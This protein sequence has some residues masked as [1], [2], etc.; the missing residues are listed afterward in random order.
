MRGALIGEAR[1]GRSGARRAGPEGAEP[2]W[3]W[4]RRRRA[5]LPALWAGGA[6]AL[7]AAGAGPAAA[8]GYTITDLGTMGGGSVSANAINN[9]GQV[10][11][12]VALTADGAATRAFLWEKGTMTDLG[13]LGGAQ[14]SASALND[15][16]QI[17]GSSTLA[18]NTTRH[19]FLWQ[20]GGMRDL[21]TLGG[22]SSY[23][24]GINA[25]GQVTGTSQIAGDGAKHAFLWQNGVMI[26][27][28][29]P[30]DNSQACGINA[31][32]HV[33][34]EVP[35]NQAFLWQVD[36]VRDLGS[37]GNPLCLPTA[38]NDRGQVV[39]ISVLGGMD[40]PPLHAFMADSDGMHDLG[41]LGG[42]WSYAFALNN[43]GDVVGYSNGPGFDDYHAFLFSGGVMQDLNALIP[44]DSGWVLTGAY[45]INDYGQI[46][47]AGSQGGEIHAFLLN[48][49]APA[50][51]DGLTASALSAS[52][53]ALS[54][55][56]NSSDETAFALWRQTD[57]GDFARIALVVPNTTGYTDSDLTP[58]TTYTY[59]VRAIGR[60]GASA[61][62]N[63]ATAITTPPSL[64]PPAFLS[65]RV[66]A[67]GGGGIEGI[68]QLAWSDNSDNET[69]FA[70]WRKGAGSDWT[71]VGLVPPNSTTFTDRGLLPGT[72]YT[73]R[74][75]ATNNSGASA[76]SNEAALTTPARPAAPAGLAVPSAGAKA[77]L[78]NWTVQGAGE[79]GITIWRKENSG[80][81]APIGELPPGSTRYFD[82]SV[83]PQTTYTY[84]LQAHNN[85]FASDW[86]SEVTATTPALP[87]AP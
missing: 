55:T 74:V 41:S 57:G 33:A 7:L 32:G 26:D 71:R 34:V 69:A 48:P 20:N 44:A 79:T 67:E 39:G 76:W 35:P 56:D 46:V 45:G 83:S 2:P 78:L 87:A 64:A 21:G 84:R 50:L 47:G 4:S 77:V 28:N 24:S 82:A 1:R 3:G 10:V 11:G 58:G 42:N 38:L 40:R 61:W 25:A 31:A 51:P 85:S 49:P 80:D 62:S 6:L 66:P 60:G 9:R 73:Y 23:A 18:D 8:Q 16:G 37:L 53:I 68:S 5:A 72:T 13:S 22:S 54:W 30:S 75:R 59:R 14:S 81:W 86:S 36:A 63:Y 15:A 19:A 52:R 12:T 43:S 29:V 65:A 70:I 27:L 17:V